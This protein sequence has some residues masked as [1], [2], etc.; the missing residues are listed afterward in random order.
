MLI[1]LSFLQELSGIPGIEKADVDGDGFID[2]NE[3]VAVITKQKEQK[4]TNKI[5]KFML[6]GL[7]VT[8][9]VTIGAVTGLTYFVVSTLKDT[10]VDS[11]SGQQPVLTSKT[12]APIA[13][14]QLLYKNQLETSLFYAPMEDLIKIEQLA[15]D[16]G[17]ENITLQSFFKISGFVRTVR[18]THG[19][20]RSTDT[21][22]PIHLSCRTQN[23]ASSPML[24]RLS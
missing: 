10:K 20:M 4:S 24:E 9:L 2:V 11:I 19:S 18:P 6:L 5:L 15:W 23:S 21:H 12:G 17:T 7:F 14:D 1:L 3:L 16:Q 8:L 22:P 13:T